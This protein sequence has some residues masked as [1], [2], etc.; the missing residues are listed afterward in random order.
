MQVMDAQLEGAIRLLDENLIVKY[1]RG[2]PLFNHH[3]T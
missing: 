3:R 1:F 2:I